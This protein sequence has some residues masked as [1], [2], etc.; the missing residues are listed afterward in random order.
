[1]MLLL[2]LMMLLLLLSLPRTWGWTWGFVSFAW[3]QG[4]GRILHISSGKLPRPHSAVRMRHPFLH[5]RDLPSMPASSAPFCVCCHVQCTAWWGRWTS[6]P[7]W[8]ASTA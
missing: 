3:L 6:P 1:M 4:Y 7:T 5:L 8:P 2:L